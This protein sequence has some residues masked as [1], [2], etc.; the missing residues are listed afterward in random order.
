MLGQRGYDSLSP[1]NSHS[2]SDR[3]LPQNSRVQYI[4]DDI[5]LLT[6]QSSRLVHLQEK[7]THS[8]RKTLTESECQK[9][10]SDIRKRALK[11]IRKN[12]SKFVFLWD[13]EY[14]GDQ[15]CELIPLYMWLTSTLCS[16]RF[17]LGM[18]VGLPYITILISS[19][20]HPENHVNNA[21]GMSR[22]Q[23][24]SILFNQTDFMAIWSLLIRSWAESYPYGPWH[25][26][27]LAK[28]SDSLPCTPPR[29]SLQTKSPLDK[30]YNSYHWL[31]EYMHFWMNLQRNPLHSYSIHVI[32]PTIKPMSKI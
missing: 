29:T 31:S 27:N 17:L 14:K 26:K 32:T 1:N 2:T 23:Q 18:G 30:G 19:V 6:C 10:M 28:N 9:T 15:W 5:L 13:Y 20:E 16:G 8:L 4:Y 11:R 12:L 21:Y 3:N 24:I 22:I 25:H 7:I